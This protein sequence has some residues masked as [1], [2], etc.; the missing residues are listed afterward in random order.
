[1]VFW[2]APGHRLL[3]HTEMEARSDIVVRRCCMDRVSAEFSH[4]PDR[5]RSNVETADRVRAAR[6]EHSI[7]DG[8]A[9][10]RFSHLTRGAARP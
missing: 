5:L 2:P 8:H 6:V 7:E 4:D 10:S 9:D 3:S 1:M